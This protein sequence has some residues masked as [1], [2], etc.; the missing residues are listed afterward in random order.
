M[1]IGTVIGNV[2]ATR[3]NEQLDG[4]KLMIVDPMPYAGHPRQYP[5]VAVDQIGAGIGERVLVVSGSSARVSVGVG[6]QPIDHVI[7][8]IV[9]Q[10]DLGEG[11]R[12]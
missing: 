6:K 5:V 2:W 11:T 7:V 3:K 12:R 10:V 1:M 9:D 4:C 8:G